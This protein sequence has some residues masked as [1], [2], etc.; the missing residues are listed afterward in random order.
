MRKLLLLTSCLATTA[1]IL[2]AQSAADIFKDPQYGGVT[3]RSI[4]DLFTYAS[5]TPNTPDFTGS[6][7][8][9]TQTGGSAII[10]SGGNIYSFSNDMRFVLAASSPQKL[11]QITL[12]IRVMGQENPILS[13][14]LHLNGGATILPPTISEQVFYEEFG[15]E[16]G[17]SID[18]GMAYTWDLTGYDVTAYEI[19]FDLLIHES[20]DAVQL[21]TT[22]DFV[23]PPAAPEIVFSGIENGMFALRFTTEAG[24]NYQVKWSD[25]LNS[26]NNLGAVVSGDGAVHTVTDA[27]GQ[28]PRFYRVVLP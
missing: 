15:V 14:N 18:L 22:T 23:V 27:L 5:N 25:N 9:I 1:T 2:S 16:F 4:W 24:R 19:V 28:N 13:M 12:Q 20:L 21:D 11:G 7:G 6:V 3:Q 10:T 26:W 17:E 8:T